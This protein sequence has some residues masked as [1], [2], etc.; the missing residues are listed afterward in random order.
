MT[1]DALAVYVHIP[2]CTS[3][4][5]YCN[6]YFETGWSPRILDTV[7][8]QSLEEL[9]LRYEAL[10]RPRVRTLYLGGGTPSVI[11]PG[12]LE[13]YLGRILSILDVTERRPLAELEM[14]GNP[15]NTDDDLISALFRAAPAP[16]VQGIRYSL[17]VQ[18]FSVDTLSLLGRRGSPEASR[19]ALAVLNRHQQRSGQALFHQCRSDIRNPR[20]GR[21]AEHSGD[22]G[23]SRAPGGIR[24]RRHQLVSVERGAGHPP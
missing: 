24:S 5:H 4:C 13:T 22:P 6:F 21:G 18:S 9:E 12:R 20:Q 14:E 1:S 10:G 11:P 16:S 15:E 17:G 23:R 8:E 19:N 7:L 3:R 2:F